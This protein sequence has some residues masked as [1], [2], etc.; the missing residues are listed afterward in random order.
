MRDVDVVVG[1]IRDVPRWGVKNRE[2]AGGGDR[3]W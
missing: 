1:D 2:W 3:R